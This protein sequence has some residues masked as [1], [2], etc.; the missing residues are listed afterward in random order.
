L[1]FS[2]TDANDT[3]GLICLLT[4][5]CIS[6]VLEFNLMLR[7]YTKHIY[8]FDIYHYPGEY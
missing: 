1:T 2:T 6:P 8:I 7:N 4:D 3:A 5:A